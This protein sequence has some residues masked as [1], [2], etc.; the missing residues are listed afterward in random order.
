ML[1]TY[2]CALK[3]SAT[4]DAEKDAFGHFQVFLRVNEG[5]KTASIAWHTWRGGGEILPESYYLFIF[6]RY[7]CKDIRDAIHTHR[8]CVSALLYTCLIQIPSQFGVVF[9]VVPCFVLACLVHPN[10]NKDFLS[11]MAWTFSM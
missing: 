9:L 10:L 1:S 6:M 3:Y 7:Y 2:F 5:K 8:T 4:Y 11:D